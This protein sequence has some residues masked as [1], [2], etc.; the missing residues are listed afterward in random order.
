MRLK[1]ELFEDDSVQRIIEDYLFLYV[2][3]VKYP[4]TYH[5]PW[6]DNITSDD[7]VM[8]NP[9]KWFSGKEVVVTEKMDGEN[10]TLYWDGL[11]ARSVDGRSH[12]TQD[13]VKNFHSQLA[14]EIPRGWRVCG[15]NMWATHSVYYDDLPSYFLGFS[16]WNDKNECLS[17]D[18]TLE[19][20]EL[21]GITPV[22]EICRGIYKDHYGAFIQDIY[23]EQW[24]GM[25][26]PSEMNS[27]GGFKISEGYI[28]RNADSF[29]YKD[30][31]HNVAKY[32]RQN[33]AAGQKH[34][35]YGSKIERN[36]L[37]RY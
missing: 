1:G 22:P 24:L 27:Y 3:R 6:S 9:S 19:W 11:H 25:C 21:L 12:P 15:E 10:T 28:I 5:L 35:F 7:R 20:F 33:F 4:R 36:N 26:E 34:W 23:E 14:H 30:F 29:H 31:R 18:D 37:G 16:V 13:W 8:S 17:W 32:V 2:E